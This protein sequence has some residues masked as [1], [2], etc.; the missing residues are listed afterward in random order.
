MTTSH[1]HLDDH[2]RAVR[3]H[4]P[5][6]PSP[7]SAWGDPRATAIVVPGGPVP[8]SLHGIPFASWCPPSD[9]D[10]WWEAETLRM[11]I[12]EPAF[13]CPAG[14]KPAAGALVLEPDGRAWAV[15]PTNRFGGH[16]W[17]L[18]KGRTDGRSLAATALVEVFEEAGLRIR[19]TGFLCDM[20]RK[21]TYTRFFLAERVGG[22]PATMG[23]ESQ[24]AVLAPVF[25]LRA[26]LTHLGDELVLDM[27]ERY[28][29]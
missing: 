20:Q 17:T 4:S 18:P 15:A 22:S 12:P 23:W 8:A 21:E 9:A 6:T 27:F 13:A 14:I 11:A 5:T 24:A 2:G 1:P 19:L 16:M 3:I 29:Q 26:M 10:A 25:S 7:A 28:F